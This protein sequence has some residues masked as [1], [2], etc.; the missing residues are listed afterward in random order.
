MLDKLSGTNTESQNTYLFMYGPN[1]NQ[2]GASLTD[3]K[4]SQTSSNVVLTEAT[5]NGDGTWSYDWYTAIP[6][7]VGTYTVYVVNNKDA[8]RLNLVDTAYSTLSFVFKKPTLTATTS[9]PSVAKGDVLYIK[10]FAE[11]DPS[12]VAIWIMGKNYATRD[13]VSVTSGSEFNYELTRYMTSNMYSGQYFVVIQHPM[14]NKRFDIVYN[15]VNGTITNL[16]LGDTGTQ[17]F[18]FTGEGSLQGSDAATALL[19]AIND[20]N[21]DDMYAKLIFTIAGPYI[22][23][24]SI[25]TKYVGDQVKVTGTTNLAAGTNLMLDV[26]SSTFRPTSKNETDSYS[27]AAVS[28]YVVKSNSTDG[29]NT[30]SVDFDTSTFHPDTYLVTATA[31]GNDITDTTSFTVS[32]DPRPVIIPQSIPVVSNNIT[33]VPTTPP[34]V[35]A[36]PTPTPAPVTTTKKPLPGYGALLALSGLVIVAFVIVRRQ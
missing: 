16:N 7:D 22:L 14:Q 8:T 35:Q 6:I 4:Y 15:E 24:N 23:I 28:A 18:T 21:I 30:F 11:G 9:Q 31:I 36:L 34:I 5:T 12:E 25:G 29:I 13:T 33:S 19:N 10:G 17:I 32:G 1:L 27:G 20:Q 2:N 26:A 3:P